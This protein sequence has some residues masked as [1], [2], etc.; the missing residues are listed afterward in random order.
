V[1]NSMQVAALAAA[2]EAGDP[3]QDQQVPFHRHAVDARDP[4][5]VLDSTYEAAEMVSY[6]SPEAV[7]GTPWNDWLVQCTAGGAYEVPAKVV[8]SFRNA[9]VV[10]WRTLLTDR[11][12]HCGLPAD[13][14]LHVHEVL[15][16]LTPEIEGF[17]I[18]DDQV[19]TTFAPG[20]PAR[21]VPGRGLFVGHVE[22][23]NHGST[24][25]RAIPMMLYLMG[26]G[27]AFDYVIV[28]DRSP[29]LRWILDARGFGHVPMITVRET[30]GFV[31]DELLTA[32][33]FDAEGILCSR[34]MAR[35]RAIPGDVDTP[36]RVYV[37][38]SLSSGI[39]PWYRVLVNELEVEEAMS[40]RGF[41]SIPMEAMSPQVQVSLMRSAS[42]V[43]GPSGSGMLNSVFS[44]PGTPVVDVEGMTY[45]V[46]Q[47]AKLYGSSGKRTAFVFGAFTEDAGYEP[48]RAWRVDVDDVMQA[49]DTLGVG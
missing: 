20:A 48:H 40:R 6:P 18:L 1:L 17:G 43:V 2:A 34:T 30:A 38:R 27:L 22:P 9:R 49:C 19:L 10:G 4:G 39:R 25:F 47:H 29:W 37:T 23:G 24:L 5:E 31:F 14:G 46:R 12:L 42:A 3:L 8:R 45:T 21:T 11:G 7:L 13:S 44:D 36:Q 16:Q 28:P 41:R 32:D 26:Q 33:E 15:R 35:M